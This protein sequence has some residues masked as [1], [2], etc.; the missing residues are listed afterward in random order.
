[1]FGGSALL[2]YRDGQWQEVPLPQG[3]TRLSMMGMLSADEGWF[4]D[5]DRRG[6]VWHYKAGVWE[7]YDTPPIGVAVMRMVNE[8][9]GWAVGDGILHY[10]NK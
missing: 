5:G 1:M 3:S 10:T 8:N 9:E 6:R 2:R 7:K 4:M